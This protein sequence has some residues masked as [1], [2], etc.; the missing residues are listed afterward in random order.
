MRRRRAIVNA[1]ERR[2]APF[3]YPLPSYIPGCLFWWPAYSITGLND[4]DAITTWPDFGP[5]VNDQVWS[6][7]KALYKTNIVG[8]LPA[9]LFN[10]TSDFFQSTSTIS[11]LAHVFCIAQY[12]GATFG[13]FSGLIGFNGSSATDSNIIFTGHSGTSHFY[14]NGDASRKRSYKLNGFVQSDEEAPMNAVGICS[15]TYNLWAAKTIEIRLGVDRQ[16]TSAG[17]WWTGY[18]MDSFGFNRVLQPHEELW[19]LKYASN[20]WGVAAPQNACLT[21]LA[22]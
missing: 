6:S 17:R 22:F 13:G 3:P 4:G 2:D 18:I 5:L 20:T 16:D 21:N 19:M 8:N 12:S 14:N 11:G 10:G 9:V 1:R 7:H 15:S